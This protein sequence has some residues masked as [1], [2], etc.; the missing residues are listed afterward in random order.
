MWR[1]LVY[2]LLMAVAKV[3]T[4]AWLIRLNIKLSSPS[5]LPFHL[6]PALAW[7]QGS[8]SANGFAKSRSTRSNA[9][10]QA[11]PDYDT[12]NSNSVRWTDPQEVPP[13]PSDSGPSRL[14]TLYPASI[15]GL[16]MIARGEIGFLIASLAESQNIFP[17]TGP[18]GTGTSRLYLVVVWAIMLCTIAG[19]LSLGALV[20]RVKRLQT[21]REMMDDFDPLDGWGT[22]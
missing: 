2:G 6:P 16:A 3:I 11:Q 4:G 5:S 19:P 8:T 9:A 15:T 10:S 21:A 1:G 7:C 20:R 12:A 18:D 14:R 17:E 13:H 22:L